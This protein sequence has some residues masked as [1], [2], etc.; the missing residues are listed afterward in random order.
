MVPLADGQD[1]PLR[2]L[3]VDDEPVIL[4]AMRAILETQNWNVRTAEDGFEGL[5][6][7]RETAPDLII[8]DLRMPNMSGFEFLAVV[9]R[10]F[11]HIPVIAISGEFL[12]DGMRP[13]L[14]VDAFLLKGGYTPDQLF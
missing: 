8:S 13:G 1:Y 2:V 7:L 3:V 11:P 10:R 9:R 5:R 6:L 14:L 4:P 12:L